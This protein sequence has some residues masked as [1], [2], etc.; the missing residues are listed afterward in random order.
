MVDTNFPPYKQRSANEGNNNVDFKELH[1]FFTSFGYRLRELGQYVERN[2]LRTQ[3]KKINQRSSVAI[4]KL[5]NHCYGNFKW[6]FFFCFKRRKFIIIDALY[7][8]LD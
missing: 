5:M 6:L 4:N 2:D 7:L 3:K 1:V 8:K